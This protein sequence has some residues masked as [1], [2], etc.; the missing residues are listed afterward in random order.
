MKNASVHILAFAALVLCSP[1]IRAQNTHRA[2]LTGASSQYFSATDSASLSVTGDHTAEMW[3]KLNSAPGTNLTHDLIGKWDET[4]NNRSYLYR[5]QDVA[6]TKQFE[7][8]I[9]T[10]GAAGTAV[11]RTL[12]YTLG[13]GTWYHLAFVYTAAS[14]S[15][16]IY[17]NGVAA[18]AALT[19]FPTSIAD[20]TG[21]FQIGRAPQG[22]AYLDGS[23][24]EVRLWSGTR[25]QAQIQGAMFSEV[26]ANDPALRGYWKLN[27]SLADAT[28]NGN[29]L[30]CLAVSYEG[31]NDDYENF[32]T[33]GAAG[34]GFK[35]PADTSLSRVA[36]YGSKGIS[37][38]GTTFTVEIR[39]GSITGSVVATQTFNTSV[40]TAYGLPAWNKLT[41]TTPVSL[42]AGIQY[43]LRWI[44]NNGS[45]NDELRWSIDTT[46]PTYAD[47]NEWIGTT[48]YT[49]RDRSFRLYAGVAFATNDLPFST[50]STIAGAVTAVGAPAGTVRITAT[51]IGG[52][53]SS[54]TSIATPGAYTIPGLTTGAAYNVSAYIDEDNDSVKD[55]LEWGGSYAGNPLLLDG[56]KTGITEETAG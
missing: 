2:V 11:V 49:T 14:G 44:A 41:L 47:G 26:A 53:S 56:D 13:P 52:G 25:T 20:M 33:S 12:N 30:E 40:L 36:F 21:N 27:N 17:V 43:F 42:S 10:D 39:T 31:S 51:P 23:V 7:A 54:A 22:S 9:S 6:G 4:G 35:V 5:Y 3:V 16:Q 15:V 1:V 34:Q 55:P 24:D 19:G 37:S 46:I 48:E 32:G 50:T 8:R 18:G 28:A 45:S 29:T 38:S